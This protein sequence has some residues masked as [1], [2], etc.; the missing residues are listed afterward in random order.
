M[1]W[2]GEAS[3]PQRERQAT[4]QLLQPTFTEQQLTQLGSF[5]GYIDYAREPVDDLEIFSKYD[6]ES[7]QRQLNEQ[8]RLSSGEYPK[9][10]KT[11]RGEEDWEPASFPIV[12]YRIL[13]NASREGIDHVISWS[14]HGRAFQVHKREAF[15]AEVMPK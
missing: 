7:V 12:L 1:M 15:E 8:H 9:S 6:K 11:P 13:S 3:N 5:G 2:G 10:T 14:S 4:Q